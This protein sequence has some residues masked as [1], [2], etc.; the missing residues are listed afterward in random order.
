MRSRYIKWNNFR[1]IEGTRIDETQVTDHFISRN[2]VPINRRKK[3]KWETY[4]SIKTDKKPIWGINENM[5][6]VNTKPQ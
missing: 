1:E 6:D 3:I 4:T 2:R 5:I